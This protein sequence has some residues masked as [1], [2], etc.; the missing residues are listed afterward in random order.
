MSIK[1][2]SGYNPSYGDITTNMVMNILVVD[3][4][5]IRVIAH[6]DAF[7]VIVASHFLFVVCE[8]MDNILGEI[9]TRATGSGLEVNPY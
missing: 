7:V 8:V 5:K 6:V 3:K 2:R 4:K 1:K 9:S